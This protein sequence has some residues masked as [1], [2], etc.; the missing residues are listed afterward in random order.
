MYQKYACILFFFLLKTFPPFLSPTSTILLL[1]VY[2]ESQPFLLNEKRSADTL[3]LFD[4]AL[5]S[6]YHFRTLNALD[7]YP[8]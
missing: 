5:M 3:F 1:S 4:S 2:Y 8:Q 6:L 7:K